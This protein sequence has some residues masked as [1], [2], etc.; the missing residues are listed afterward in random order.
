MHRVKCSCD[1]RV[2]VS[3]KVDNVGEWVCDALVPVIAHD[4]DGVNWH[5]EFCA[6]DSDNVANEVI[7]LLAWPQKKRLISNSSRK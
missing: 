2:A 7:E 3:L 6:L 1:K 4:A 5:A